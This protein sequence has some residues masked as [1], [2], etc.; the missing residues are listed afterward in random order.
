M[1]IFVYK[2]LG[3]DG[4]TVEGRI[5]ASDKVDALRQLE[6]QGVAPYQL[7]VSGPEDRVYAR[8]KARPQDRFRFMRQLAVLLKAGMPLLDAFETVAADEPCRDLA[9]QAAQV[10]QD[11]RSGTPLSRAFTTHM[12][13]L[14]PYA[15]RLIELGEAT[16]QLPK[17]LNDI[18]SQMEL[19]LK[20]A[21]EV[22]NALAYPSF[23]AVA[24]LGA[25]AFMFLFVVPRFANL[26]G[27]D[28]SSLPGFSRWVIETGVF[29]SENLILTLIVI[30]AVV[31]GAGLLARNPGVRSGILEA[32]FRMPVVGGFL[33]ASEV[34]RWARACATALSGGAPLLDA[35]VL[36]ESSVVSSKR[37]QSLAEARR[38][39]RAGE[40]IDQAL[41]THTDFDAMTLNLVRTGRASAS[42]DEMLTFIA[43]I[44]EE[45]SRNR[46]KQLTS[47]AEPLAVLF[48]AGV[49]G[50]VVV[51]LVMAMTSLYDVAL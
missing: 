8:R 4:A 37:R 11:L 19:D 33:R 26:L 14:P 7:A 41:K 48:I 39:I 3:P 36:A 5:S 23:L 15:T 32:L 40:A 35:L 21:S 45:E 43:E 28:R 25:V 1:A 10:R 16:G 42:M 30:A 46:A 2:A 9:Q 38:A 24:G 27:D 20:S 47:L 31:V 49:V 22:R 12:A 50:L 13:K 29:M 18:A 34:A 6:G 44:Y 51:S 17:A